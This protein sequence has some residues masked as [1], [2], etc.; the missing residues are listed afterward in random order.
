MSKSIQTFLARLGAAAVAVTAVAVVAYWLLDA[1]FVSAKEFAPVVADVDT[2][3][4]GLHELRADVQLGN[5][6]QLAE[7]RNTPW[8]ECVRRHDAAK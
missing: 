6:L 1:E 7:K 4:S 2:L 3:K 5:C 8:L